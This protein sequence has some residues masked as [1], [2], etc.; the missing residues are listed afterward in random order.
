MA[1]DWNRL[2]SSMTDCIF[3]EADN[4]KM[5]TVI[6]RNRLAYARL[7]NF[8]LTDGHVEVVPFRHVGSVFDLTPNELTA[9]WSLVERVR[10]L[11][12][13]CD[14]YTIGV[15]DGPARCGSDGAA[16]AFAC[17]SAPVR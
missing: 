16:Y 6:G 17:D 4:P 12:G 14:G 1:L 3:C 8:P 5:N 9:L 10:P 7:D 15:N 13:G 11:L 2:G